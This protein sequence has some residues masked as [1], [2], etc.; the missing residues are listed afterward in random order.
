M[1]YEHLAL[2]GYLMIPVKNYLSAKEI[3]KFFSIGSNNKP[4]FDIESYNYVN[5]ERFIDM[6]EKNILGIKYKVVKVANDND[7][8]DR[9]NNAMVNMGIS[10]DDITYNTLRMEMAWFVIER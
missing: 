3:Y 7:I 1:L 10:V 9:V 5:I 4:F 2:N 8:V 6:L